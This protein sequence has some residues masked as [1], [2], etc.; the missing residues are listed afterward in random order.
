MAEA[1]YGV[2]NELI[3]EARKKL[4]SN[5]LYVLDRGYQKLKSRL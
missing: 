1:M 5:F 3:E 2:D 4:P